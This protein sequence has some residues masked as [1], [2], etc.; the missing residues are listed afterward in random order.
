[1]LFV[2]IFKRYDVCKRIWDGILSFIIGY[3]YF[4]IWVCGCKVLMLW[5]CLFWYFWDELRKIY[6]FIC[7]VYFECG[8]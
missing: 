7:C 6:R 3:M 1:M 5:S 2:N 8:G 4:Y